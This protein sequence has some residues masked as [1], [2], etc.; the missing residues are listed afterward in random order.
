MQPDEMTDALAYE[1]LS[2]QHEQTVEQLERLNDEL[3]AMRQSSV[4][5][6]QVSFTAHESGGAEL[7]E[8]V[9]TLRDLHEA[10]SHVEPKKC[11]PFVSH[12]PDA[13]GPCE[14]CERALFLH[15]RLDEA[16]AVL[17]KHWEVK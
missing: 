4:G 7:R 2:E 6:V 17:A 16:G 10:A 11:I 14:E 1:L 9:Q 8:L 12:G 15:Q 3:R 5:F 13:T